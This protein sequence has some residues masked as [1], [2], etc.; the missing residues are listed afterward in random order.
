MENVALIPFAFF[1]IIIPLVC[2]VVIVK[3][4]ICYF[5]HENWKITK[6]TIIE[7]KVKSE[8]DCADKPHIVYEYNVNGTKY[9]SQEI[10]LGGVINSTKKKAAKYVEMY[11]LNKEVDVLYNPKNPEKAFVEV[12]ENC[13]P[14]YFGVSIC[15]IFITSGIYILFYVII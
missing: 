5:D 9:K 4:I 3:K 6:G 2:L 8:V 7:S 1:L 10:V 11:Y 15:L 12:G 14:Y 13:L